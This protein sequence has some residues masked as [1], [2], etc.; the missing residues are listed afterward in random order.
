[1]IEA[2][3]RQHNKQV[4]CWQTLRRRGVGRRSAVGS[5]RGVDAQRLLHRLVTLLPGRQQLP[6]SE[7]CE[8][9]SSTSAPQ[10]QNMRRHPWPCKPPPTAASRHN[11]GPAERGIGFHQR[12]C[13]VHHADGGGSAAENP[14]PHSGPHL[15][16]CRRLGPCFC[17]AAGGPKMGL[18]P[19]WHSR[20]HLNPSER[21]AAAN[22]CAAAAG[23]RPRCCWRALPGVLH[24]HS[25]PW[26]RLPSL[27]GLGWMGA[28]GDMP[29]AAP[30]QASPSLRPSQPACLSGTAKVPL[31][32]ASSACRPRP[33]SPSSPR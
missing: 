1:M 4:R 24:A 27:P 10:W 25:H 17:A 23:D 31:S 26:E 12:R 7:C 28:P 21:K 3:E 2:R 29:S 13:A 14:V 9:D 18:E 11:A 32:H 16:R 15:H 8:G 22:S 19:V 6:A 33:T 5:G 20:P 30:P